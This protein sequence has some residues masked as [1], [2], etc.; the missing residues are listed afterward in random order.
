MS[1]FKEH[2]VLNF[3]KINWFPGQGTKMILAMCGSSHSWVL[4]LHPVYGI[5]EHK[6]GVSNT[7]WKKTKDNHCSATIYSG[8]T[9]W[10]PN[11]IIKY[12]LKK[13]T[14]YDHF[15]HDLWIYL[16]TDNMSFASKLIE[17]NTWY[18]LNLPL[19]RNGL[20]QASGSGLSLVAIESQPPDQSAPLAH[21]SLAIGGSHLLP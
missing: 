11:I 9:Q 3:E 14:T 19:D 8:E 18:H 17:E 7:S 5:S 1:L 20:C 10:R 16:Y 6:S 2:H 13:K 21:I 4:S 12:F 15:V